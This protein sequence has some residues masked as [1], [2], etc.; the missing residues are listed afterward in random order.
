MVITVGATYDTAYTVFP[1]GEMVYQT[2]QVQE[3]PATDLAFHQQLV[4]IRV[5][6]ILLLLDT[7][8]T[9]NEVDAYLKNR[10][11]LTKIGVVGHSLGGAA[12]FELAKIDT[13][14]KAGVIMDGSLQLITHEKQLTT[15]FLLMRQ[16]NST[17]EQ[18][19][20]V[21]NQ[22]VAAAYSEGQQALYDTLGGFKSFIK[23]NNAD[24]LSFSDI[25][26]LFKHE[27]REKSTVESV[28]QVIN[29]LSIAFL[30]EFLKGKEL[31]YSHL[32]SNR[33]TPSEFDRID[34]N[35]EVVIS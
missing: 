12:V 31:A 28:H 9:W 33:E 19:T 6:D 29:Q 1:N 15:P 27:D 17:Y 16:E 8:T 35:G 25:P 7:M 32:I 13:R 11:D 2:K 34:Q 5:K 21:W 22:E 24:H 30:D 26:V 10:M 14:I 18:M 4:Q 3:V 20:Q 23:V